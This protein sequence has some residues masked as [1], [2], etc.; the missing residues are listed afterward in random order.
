MPTAASLICA[1]SNADANFSKNQDVKRLFL[2]ARIYSVLKTGFRSKITTFMTRLHGLA[3]FREP[4]PKH[5]EKSGAFQI[6]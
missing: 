4:N 1:H 5:H 6:Y 2:H 3:T